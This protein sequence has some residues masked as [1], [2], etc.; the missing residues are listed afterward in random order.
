MKPHLSKAETW[1]LRYAGLHHEAAKFCDVLRSWPPPEESQPR[2]AGMPK[3]FDEAWV[4]LNSLE[5]YQLIEFYPHDKGAT[6]R[7][8][9]CRS[10]IP[11]GIGPPGH[12]GENARLGAVFTLRGGTPDRCGSGDWGHIGHRQS[13]LEHLGSLRPG[14]CAAVPSRSEGG[15]FD[16]DLVPYLIESRRPDETRVCR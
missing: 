8:Q 10:S 15:S 6:I 13:D 7:R 1:L 9:P 16:L 2:V 3:T 12:R 4:C 5:R 14:G 11:L